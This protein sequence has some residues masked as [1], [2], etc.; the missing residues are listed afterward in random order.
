MSTLEKLV[1]KRKKEQTKLV[2]GMVVC[3]LFERMNEYRE[4]QDLTWNEMLEVLFEMA[5][6]ELPRKKGA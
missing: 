3:S 5:L 2:Q 6:A 1:A 4:G